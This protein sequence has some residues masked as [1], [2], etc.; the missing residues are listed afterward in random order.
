MTMCCCIRIG[1]CVSGA[2]VMGFE[3]HAKAA[4]GKTLGAA[5]QGTATYFHAKAAKGK[6][7]E[8]RKAW[9]S[10]E[11]AGALRV[12]CENL[13]AL[14]VKLIGKFYFCPTIGSSVPIYSDEVR[15]QARGSSGNLSPKDKVPTCSARR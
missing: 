5:T 3:F 2:K 12:L 9:N 1:S 8:D 15:E 4:E 14:C 11:F 13:C 7:C 6:T 10:R